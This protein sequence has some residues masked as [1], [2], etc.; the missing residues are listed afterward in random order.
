VFV[1]K[2]GTA[3]CHDAPHASSDSLDLVAP[4]VVAR[5]VGIPA[6]EGGLLVDPNRPEDSILYR[7]LLAGGAGETMPP[8]APLDDATVACVL[9]WIRGIAAVGAADSG[10]PQPAADAAEGSTTF[11]PVRVGAG[12]A[13]PYTDQDGNT[14]SID[15]DFTGG[16]VDSR[17]NAISGTSD[18]ALYRNERWGTSFSYA[19]T[20]PSADYVVTLKFAE[21]YDGAQVNGGRVFNMSINDQPALQSFDIFAAAGANAALD[22]SF[23]VT[24]RGG[25]I[26]LRFD[27]VRGAAKV[28][29]IAITAK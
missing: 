28:D 20:V 13:M 8:A 26:V 24:V 14:W 16:D 18:G 17:T 11:T 23:P 1:N 27:G 19:F 15:A 5:L 10:A 25:M 3:G 2:C 22:K 4:N 12:L 21:T 6:F 9:S 7:R 29:A